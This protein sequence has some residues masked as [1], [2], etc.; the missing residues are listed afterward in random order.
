MG[1]TQ[2]HVIKIANLGGETFQAIGMIGGGAPKSVQNPPFNV[3][4]K[5]IEIKTLYCNRPTNVAKREV[6]V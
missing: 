4:K 5:D 6:W 1:G 3:I 2:D